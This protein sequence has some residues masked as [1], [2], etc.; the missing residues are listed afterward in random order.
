MAT[1]TSDFDYDLPPSAIAQEAIEPRDASRLIVTS[2]LADRRFWE[3]PELLHPG[4]LLVVN[5]TRVRR[6]RLATVRVDTGGRVEVLL[7]DG[8][9]DPEWQVMVRP[10]RRLRSGVRLATEPGP[11]GRR[12]TIDLLTDPDDGVARAHLGGGDVDA[13]V[14]AIGTVPLPPY[15]HGELADDERYQTVFADHVGSAA[16][17]TAALHFTPDLVARIEDAGVVIT[18]VD[19]EVG[20][21]T[22]RPVTVDDL[23]DHRIH[24]ERYTVPDDAAD[25]IAAARTR[26]GRVVA[27]GTT[28]VRTLETAAVG[29]GVG[30]ESGVSDLFITPGYRCSVVDAVLTNFHAPRTTLIALVA[31]LIGPEW[32]AVY[33]TAL[34]RG[35]RFLSFGDA[36]LIDEIH[37]DARRRS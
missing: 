33:A 23:D 6:A 8:R 21:D 26:G 19:L 12:L 1:P 28:V 13:I 35:Y 17:P 3:L 27:V 24:T 36:M 16:A 7:L 18:A 29:S 31:A 37:P 30:A 34:A 14:K 9:D 10:S 15:F 25:A 20:L 5:R 4:D 2:S 11:D 22:F 32:R